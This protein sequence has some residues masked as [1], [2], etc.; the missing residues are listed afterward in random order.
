MTSATSNRLKD[1]IATRTK[2][3]RDPADRNVVILEDKQSIALSKEFGCSLGEVYRASLDQGVWPYRYIRNRD[4]LSRREQLALSQSRV[5]VIGSGGL[6]GTVILL[7]ARIG[8]GY[9]TVVDCDSFDETNLNRQVVS[10]MDNT[11]NPKAEEARKMVEGINPAVSV[12]SLCL[13][14]DSD[15]APEILSDCHVVVDALDNVPDRLALEAVARNLKIPLV[16]GALAGFEG[17]VMTVFPEDPGLKLI[18]GEDIS[19]DDPQRPEA[20][21]GVPAVTPSVI[22][23]FEAME[24][25]KILLN[26]GE[27]LRQRMLHIDLET[28]RFDIFKF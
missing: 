26:R 4:I 11:G 18:Y 9:L 3:I 2:E 7:L 12:Q 25:M 28:A 22:A 17:Q 6:G 8:V 10:T 1:G 13:K 23:S 15:S 20:V 16:H 14:I 24:V 5:A 27:V 19:K 21:M